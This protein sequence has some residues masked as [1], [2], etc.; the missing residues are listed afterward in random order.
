[1]KT[2]EGQ[3]HQSDQA[4]HQD[5][6][7]VTKYHMRATQNCGEKWCVVELYDKVVCVCDGGVSVRVC[8]YVCV[9]GKP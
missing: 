1:M 8:V 4:H 2:K 9:C 5:Q 6:P 3:R 7:S